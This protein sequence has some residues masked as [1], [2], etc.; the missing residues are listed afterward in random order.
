MQKIFDTFMFFNELDLLEIRLNILDPYVD[1]FVISEAN[2]TFSGKT[3]PLYYLENKARFKKFEQKIIHN[4]VN[5]TPNDFSNFKHQYFTDWTKSY[6]HKHNGKKLLELTKDCQIEVYQRDSIMHA[7]LNNELN[8]ND[9]ILCSDLD[10]IPSSKIFNNLNILL[11]DQEL[12]HCNQRW[13]IYYLNNYCKNDWFGTRVCKYRY[14]KTQSIDLVRYPT[15]DRSK[16]K[17]MIL[18]DSGWHFSY[19]GGEEK[20]KE[21]LESIAY[22]GNKSTWVLHFIDKIFK[23]RIKKRIE[24]NEDIFLTNREFSKVDIDENFPTYIIEN[25]NKY[26]NMIKK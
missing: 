4:I 25:K 17:G 23:N 18:E 19:L 2:I 22:K 26:K 7:L 3:K 9:I 16:Q 15:E 8:D 6:K 14:L 12:L 10:E 13:H 1:Y 11:E 21:K 5:D 20:V 24:N